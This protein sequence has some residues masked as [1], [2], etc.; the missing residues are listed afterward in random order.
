[1]PTPC[2][3]KAPKISLEISEETLGPGILPIDL[4]ETKRIRHVDAIDLRQS[5]D[6]GKRF[7]HAPF[8][9]R[10][11]QFG[12]GRQARPRTDQ[13]HIADQ[14]VYELRE[15]VNLEAAEPCAERP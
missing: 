13:T 8:P 7:Q 15:L 3:R 9:P 11:D 1:M 6:A 2:P 4:G 12:L 14:D 10:F 5:G